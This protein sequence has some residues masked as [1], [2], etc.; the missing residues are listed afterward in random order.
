[1]PIKVEGARVYWSEFEITFIRLF[2]LCVP[3][4]I[5]YELVTFSSDGEKQT[6]A[7]GA[8]CCFHDICEDTRN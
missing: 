2:A 6:P 5:D 1:M 7:A 3:S 4:I 8:E